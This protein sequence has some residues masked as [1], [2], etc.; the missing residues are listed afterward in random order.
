MN[1]CNEELYNKI[2]DLRDTFSNKRCAL[3]ALEKDIK[4]IQEEMLDLQCSYCDEWFA[5][6][7]TNYFKLVKSGETFYEHYITNIWQYPNKRGYTLYGC[8][9]NKISESVIKIEPEVKTE[10]DITNFYQLITNEHCDKMYKVEVDDIMD[11]VDNFTNRIL[12][13]MK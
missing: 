7:E 6:N 3:T 8:R 4:N 2:N 9:V 12:R 13:K 11:V 5:K 10:Y 1:T